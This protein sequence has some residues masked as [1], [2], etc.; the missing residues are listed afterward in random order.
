MGGNSTLPLC[1]V[2]VA[3]PMYVDIRF[4]TNK[5]HEPT[6]TKRSLEAVLSH[7]L[8]LGGCFYRSPLRRLEGLSLAWAFQPTTLQSLILLLS[9][10]LLAQQHA[11]RNLSLDVIIKELQ[12]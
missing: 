2:L 4:I 1:S 10:I 6:F 5:K 11:G 8:A 3:L 12:E 7:P 9:I